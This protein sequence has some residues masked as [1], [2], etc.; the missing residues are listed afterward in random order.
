MVRC[1]RAGASEP[2]ERSGPAMGPA[3][4]DGRG[5]QRATRDGA[6]V[7]GPGATAPQS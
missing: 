5:P 4:D 2:P 6:A 7:G 1:E 3:S